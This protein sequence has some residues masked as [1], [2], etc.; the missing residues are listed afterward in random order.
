MNDERDLLTAWLDTTLL[1][2]GGFVVL[3]AI[4]LSL[5]NPPQKKNNDE[6]T[7]V[8][9][10]IVHIRWGDGLDADVDLWVKAPGDAAVGYSSKQGRYFNLLRDSLGDS[11]NLGGLR[12]EFAFSNGVP[13]GE[14]CA[15][16]GLY[17]I[18]DHSLLPVTVTYDI[19]LRGDSVWN[20]TNGSIQITRVGEEKTLACFTIDERKLVVPGS[21]N[22]IERHIWRAP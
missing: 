16:A 10:V 3:A 9:N 7:P 20:I 14:Y 4:L 6:V 12:E 19:S 18:A 22:T 5:V 11:N 15:T 17:R 13:P 21:L 2:F 8:G 1:L